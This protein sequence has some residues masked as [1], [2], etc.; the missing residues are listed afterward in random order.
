MYLFYVYAYLRKDGTPYYIGKGSNLRAYNKNHT[1]KV[2]EDKSRIVFLETNL[3]EVG[4][5][6][7]ERRM[8]RWYGRKD[9]GTGVLMNRT[10]GGDAPPNHSG[11]KRSDIAKQ[12]MVE[13]HK[14]FSGMKHSSESLA[15]RTATRRE[16]GSYTPT[17]EWVSRLQGMRKDHAELYCRKVSV[18]GHEYS[19]I[20]T[21]C[22][23]VGMSYKA[24]SRRLKSEKF[25]E[26]YL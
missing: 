21:A 7:L 4:S 10:D 17:D 25:S 22:E 5:L 23:N 13:S 20:K 8:I 3:T 14:G 24:L 18:M 15:K 6:A 12:R 26:Y 16:L 9:M 2:P 19:S 1:V 11:M